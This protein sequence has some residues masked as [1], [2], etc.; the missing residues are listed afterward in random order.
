MCID[1]SHPTIRDYL[2]KVLIDLNAKISN[3][4]QSNPSTNLSNC[5]QILFMASQ[6]LIQK[7][8]QQRATPI[9]QHSSPAL[10]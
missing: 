3:Y 9:H 1:P 7:I 6:S 10:K 8:V 5:F 2:Y 4:L